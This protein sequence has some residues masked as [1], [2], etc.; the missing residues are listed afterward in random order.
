MKKFIA[1]TMLVGM[2]G[3][4]T[5]NVYAADDVIETA[6][7]ETSE[8]VCPNDCSEECPNDGVRALDGTGYKNGDMSGRGKSLGIKNSW[9]NKRSEECTND[10]VC[11]LD[12]TGYRNENTARRGKFLDDDK[13]RP[14]LENC[15]ND[16]V[17]VRDGSGFRGKI[18]N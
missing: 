7:T 14:N 15:P 9:Q 16:G 6:D 5:F 2:I 4:S 11:D 12:G 13:T 10:G 8:A 1:I 17:R 3:A 18:N